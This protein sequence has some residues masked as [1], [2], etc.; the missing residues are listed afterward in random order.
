MSSE[1]ETREAVVLPEGYTTAADGSV[2]DP[3]GNP[4]SKKYVLHDIIA[5][6]I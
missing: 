4:V 5:I 1:Q 3:E 6:C 2:V